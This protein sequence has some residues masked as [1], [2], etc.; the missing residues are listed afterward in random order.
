MRLECSTLQH[1]ISPGPCAFGNWESS[2]VTCAPIALPRLSTAYPC[3][4]LSLTNQEDVTLL[5]CR[6]QQ[7]SVRQS[8]NNAIA[9]RNKLAAGNSDLLRQGGTQRMRIRKWQ[10]I[11]IC[12]Q[13]IAI[14]W[15]DKAWAVSF[16]VASHGAIP[17]TQLPS[18][19][20]SARFVHS[21]A[22]CRCLTMHSRVAT[23]R[24]ET[25]IDFARD[26][27]EM[28]CMGQ[29]TPGQGHVPIVASYSVI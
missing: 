23:G 6:S 15:G 22:G 27:H 5:S 20:P 7:T 21:F 1:A 14:C 16:L 9:V 24:R 12:W 25:Q 26:L 19:R 4:W 17:Y 11:A 29:A 2:L 3:V 13:E 18:G 10:E 8:R 28:P